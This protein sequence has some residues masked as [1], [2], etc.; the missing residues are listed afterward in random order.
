MTTKSTTPAPRPSENAIDIDAILAKRK[1]ATGSANQFPFIA[2]GR[3]WLCMAPDL[4]GDDFKAEL[5]QLNDE[6]EN[7]TI[8]EHDA[9]VEMAFLWLGDDQAQAF[10][11]AAGEAGVSSSWI[12][13]MAISNYNEQVNANPTRPS[14]SLNRRQRRQR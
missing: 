5:A 4:G 14:S 1:E 13:Q 9:Q 12:I 6:L 3:E 10:L 2:L 8:S 7:K 11:D